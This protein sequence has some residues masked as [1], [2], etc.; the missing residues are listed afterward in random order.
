MENF[1]NTLEVKSLQ[2]LLG[3]KICI[4]PPNFTETMLGKYFT[5]ALREK[6]YKALRG[7]LPR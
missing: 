4:N 2:T 5:D 3:K 6:L 7:K 1:I